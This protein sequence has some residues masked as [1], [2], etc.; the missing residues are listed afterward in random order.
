VVAERC[1]IRHVGHAPSSVAVSDKFHGWDKRG[2]SKFKATLPHAVRKDLRFGHEQHFGV[3]ERVRGGIEL[4][5]FGSPEAGVA[6]SAH[7]A[8]TNTT[9]TTI[10]VDRPIFETRIGLAGDR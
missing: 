5:Y 6:L 9:P 8:A 2:A 1:G 7:D 4:G 10:S 3:V